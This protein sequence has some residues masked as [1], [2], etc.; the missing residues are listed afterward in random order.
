V[1]KD[2]KPLLAK[3]L[4]VQ[5]GDEQAKADAKETSESLKF[6]TY[7][8]LGFGGIALFVGAF[9]ILNTLSITVAQRSREFATLRT[10]GGS[11]RQ[12]MR[13]VVV[14]GLVV[15]IVA[16][17]LG[18]ALGLGI[19][20]GMTALFSAMGVD[21]PKAGTVFASRTVIVAMLTGTLVTLVASIVPARRATRVPPISAVREGSSAT[22]AAGPER[23]ATRGLIVTG[24]SL[25]SIA[26]GLFGGVMLALTLVLGVF[27]LFIGIAMLAPKLVK[28]LAAV[29]G[30]ASARFGGEAGRPARD[31]A[32]RN[33]GRTASRPPR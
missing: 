26:A 22:T 1:T 4:V 29:A 25:A 14:E 6:I 20:K 18:L 21:L 24:L 32:L 5:T 3:G 33:P 23:G 17:L 13:S 11:R 10:L 30:F 2:I 8:L 9:V 16:S 19:A 28:R 27:G 12:V 15:G 31:N 7:F